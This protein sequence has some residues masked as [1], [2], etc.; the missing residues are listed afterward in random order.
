MLSNRIRGWFP[1]DSKI[2]MTTMKPRW[3]KPQWI[4]LTVVATIALAFIA[5][6]G[7]QTVLRW[8]DPRLDVTASYF[9]KR[10]NATTVN[11]G[12]S[13]EVTVQAGWHGRVLPE[14]VRDV[15][16]VDAL[17]EG[18]AL[19]DG[20]NTFEYKGYGGSDQFVYTIK[21][22][23]KTGVTE[24]PNPKLFLD[25]TEIALSGTSPKLD[26]LS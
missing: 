11:V 12:D 18:T 19:V 7:V 10:V 3:K 2:K 21:V 8:S 15:K 22:T 24:L 25:G 23:E 9:E 14:L 26:V 4:A 13:V 16:V 20:V 5:Y 6:S 17:P 1:K